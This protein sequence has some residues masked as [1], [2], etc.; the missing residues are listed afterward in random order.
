MGLM[1]KGCGPDRQGMRGQT[2]VK[3]EA[4]FTSVGAELGPR[5]SP[6][7]AVLKAQDGW[8]LPQTNMELRT[9]HLS[10]PPHCTD[11]KIEVQRRQGTHSES[12]SKWTV[13]LRP[14]PVSSDCQAEA[15]PCFFRQPSLGSCHLTLKGREQDIFIRGHLGAVRE[16]GG[17]GEGNWGL[18]GPLHKYIPYLVCQNV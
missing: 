16:L 2:R 9:I 17:I 8:A 11:E 13:K 14:D 18:P 12:H 7:S 5:G 3:G 4:K 15:R 6:I 1:L 10:N